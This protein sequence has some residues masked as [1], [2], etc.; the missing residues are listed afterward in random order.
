[1]VTRDLLAQTTRLFEAPG[2]SLLLQIETNELSPLALIG[3][4][5]QTANGA[6]SPL[7]DRC[8]VVER[9]SSMTF[10]GRMVLPFNRQHGLLRRYHL[11]SLGHQAG[12]GYLVHRPY[13]RFTGPKNVSAPLVK[14]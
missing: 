10:S 13:C 9:A 14:H 7:G 6:E 5:E 11:A 4:S 12:L 1:M 8:P 3:P 2:R